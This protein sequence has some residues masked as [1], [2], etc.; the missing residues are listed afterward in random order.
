MEN[1]EQLKLR[2]KELEQT[3]RSLQDE[4]ERKNSLINNLPCTVSWINDQLEY[5]SINTELE[6]LF[7]F[8]A[9]DFH[10]QKVGFLKKEGNPFYIFINNFFS[11]DLT[12]DEIEYATDI[13][14]ETK[15]HLII[16]QKYKDNSEA[17]V[18]GFDITEKKELQNKVKQDERLRVIGELAT[19]I[20]HEIN[21]PLTVIKGY[22]EHLGETI[23]EN[24][25]ELF[26]ITSKIIKMSDRISVIV[27]SLKNLGRDHINDKKE[28]SCLRDI[29]DEVSILA[30]QK[31]MDYRVGFVIKNNIKNKTTIRCIEG[32]IIQV[33]INLIGNACES[34][35]QSDERIVELIIDEDQNNT[36][37]KVSDNGPGIPTEIK[38]RIFKPFFTTKPKGVGTGMGLGICK[39]IALKH[40]GDLT[41]ETSEKGTTF[42]LSISKN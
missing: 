12:Y 27:D 38:D 15:Y 20:I 37:F 4:I 22:S 34:L 2:V 9:S 19:G 35:Y 11:S 29:I 17:V 1:I 39:D 5:I 10:K 28:D 31:I 3:N 21:N 24:D 14:G 41:L 42:T 25:E 36:Y 23:G 30:K 13:S 33:L 6:T 16:A 26:E 32:Q 40:D 7:N 18:I 8:K